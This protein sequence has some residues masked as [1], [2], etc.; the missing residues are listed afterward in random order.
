MRCHNCDD[1]CIGCGRLEAELDRECRVHADTILAQRREIAEVKE[2]NRGLT[3]L[4]LGTR[5]QI[6]KILTDATI[7][8]GWQGVRD[9]GATKGSWTR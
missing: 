6:S 8:Q 7:M 2:A 1:D 3:L 9:E 4:L 5:Y